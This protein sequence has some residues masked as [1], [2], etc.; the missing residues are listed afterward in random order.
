VN[1]S[2]SQVRGEISNNVRKNFLRGSG[3]ITLNQ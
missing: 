2:C 3:D 1:I